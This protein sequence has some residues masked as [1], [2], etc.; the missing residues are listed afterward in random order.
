MKVIISVGGKFHAFYLAKEL[1]KRGF[2]D[3]IFTS[4]P[5]FK[6]KD[7][8]IDK[9]KVKCLIT[10]EILGRLFYRVPYIRNKIDISYYTANLF[11]L[12]V[13]R[14]IKSCD[15]FVGW[16]SFCLFTIRKIR[17]LFPYIKVILERLSTHIE[18]QRD[19]LL[20][21]QKITGLKVNIPSF[22]IVDKEINEYRESDYI[23]IPSTFV[24]DTF[25]AK[26]FSKDKLLQIPFGVDIE[27]FKP[28]LKNDKVF[29]IISVGISVRKGIH[30]L[31]K[32]V[33]ELAIKDLDVWLIGKVSDD[34]K[35][36]L[37]RYSHRFKY[38]GPIPHDELYKY[39][40]QGSVFVLTSIEEGLAFCILE[41]MAC[42]LPVICSTNTG[43]RDVV[44]DG[45]DGFIVPI[46]D[47][48]SL[49]EKILFLYQHP[50]S[51]HQMGE[52]ARENI[53]S[54]FTW[55]HYIEKILRIYAK[56]YK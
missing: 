31:L 46:R 28:T 10:K 1:E 56:I 41:A 26:G 36:V 6:V 24:K 38:L 43:A 14:R 53:I 16:S 13:A 27:R 50:E 44:R 7:S 21:E 2:L 3:T 4:Y 5:Y 55:Q 47:V 9:K 17:R 51:A 34:I 40:S 15:I 49:K 30:Y 25:L 19:I 48:V 22:Y 42:G 52:R 23:S 33:E 11:D 37:K 54:S 29:R 45:I 39:Y 8:K 18:F 32:A 12:E 35:P 20:E